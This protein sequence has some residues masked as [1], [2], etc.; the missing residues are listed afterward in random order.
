MEDSFYADIR[1]CVK[2]CGKVSFSETRNLLPANQQQLLSPLFDF[3]RVASIE[4]G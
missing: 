2:H 3:Q 4:R 1:L